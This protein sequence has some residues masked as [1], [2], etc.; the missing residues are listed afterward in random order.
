MLEDG[1]PAPLEQAIPVD[2]KNVTCVDRHGRRLLQSMQSDGV[3]S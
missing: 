1:P 3:V 2:L